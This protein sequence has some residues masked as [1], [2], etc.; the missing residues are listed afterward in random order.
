MALHGIDQIISWPIGMASILRFSD[1]TDGSLPDSGYEHLVRLILKKP[2]IRVA[3][4]AGQ[5]L[6]KVDTA[7]SM[8]KMRL[9]VFDLLKSSPFYEYGTDG[10]VSVPKAGD[11]AS[12]DSDSEG[13]PDGKTGKIPSPRGKDEFNCSLEEIVPMESGIFTNQTIANLT[14]LLQT[15]T[16]IIKERNLMKFDQLN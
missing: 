12:R 7:L 9:L 4:S 1:G 10:E 15:L 3:F 2:T 16:N 5:I 13:A 8:K 14:N 11:N 6:A